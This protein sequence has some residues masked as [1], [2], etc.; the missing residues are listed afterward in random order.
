[1]KLV[2]ITNGKKSSEVI[3]SSQNVKLD[4]VFYDHRTYTTSCPKTGESSN[5]KSYYLVFYGGD[6]LRKP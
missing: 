5:K 2:V 3:V 6:N 4:D 1:M